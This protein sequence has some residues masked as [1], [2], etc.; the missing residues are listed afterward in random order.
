M[1]KDELST[2]ATECTAFHSRQEDRHT[3]ALD[4]KQTDI[5]KG[6]VISRN[7]KKKWSRGVKGEM[8]GWRD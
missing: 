5:K 8:V 4:W 7:D 3:G 6:K 2:Q 1:Q